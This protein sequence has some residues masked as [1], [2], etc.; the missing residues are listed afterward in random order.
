MYMYIYIC[1]YIY[2]PQC[3]TLPPLGDRSAHRSCQHRPHCDALRPLQLARY[4]GIGRDC[5]CAGHRQV[6][7]SPSL[8]ICL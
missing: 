5:R 2:S 4:L 7:L 8:R 6:D 1:I 3:V